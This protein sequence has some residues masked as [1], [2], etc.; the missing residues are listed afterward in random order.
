MG[1][2]K[3]GAK[4]RPSCWIIEYKSGGCWKYTQHKTRTL[5]FSLLHECHVHSESFSL[6]PAS[7]LILVTLSVTMLTIPRL[8]PHCNVVLAPT[9]LILIKT[10]V[11]HTVSW[12]QPSFKMPL[13][14]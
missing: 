9:Q 13:M 4:R 6:T 10:L 2:D 3:A 1:R 5:N 12:P 7:Y 8:Q 14:I 11:L